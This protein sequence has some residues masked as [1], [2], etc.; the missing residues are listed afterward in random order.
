MA[1][2]TPVPS[3]IWPPA[4]ALHQPFWSFGVIRLRWT[5]TF[6]FLLLLLP[7]GLLLRDPRPRAEGLERLLGQAALLQSFPAAPERPVPALWSQRLG[8]AEARRVWRQQR[9]F[10]WQFWGGDGDAGAFLAYQ[11]DSASPPPPNGIRVDDLVVVAANPL[12]KQLLQDQL[13]L[14]QPQRRGLEQRCLQRLQQEQA[15][16]WAPLGLGV[17]AG[18]AAPFLQRFQQGC[19]SLALDV[20]NLGIT[21][22]AAAASGLLSAPGPSAPAV[23]PPPLPAELLLEWRGPALEGLL[24]GLLSRQLIREPLAAR[25]GI[26]DAQMIMLGRV[27]F[28]LRLRPLAQGPFQ[29]GLELELAVSGDRSPWN[30]M[31]AGIVEPLESQGLVATPSGSKV[32][33]AMKWRQQNGQVVGGWRWTLAGSSSPELLLFLGPEPPAPFIPVLR[34]P[35]LG[36]SMQLRLRPAALAERGLLPPELPKP[37]QRANQLSLTAAP[38]LP[39]SAL[40]Q[41]TGQLQLQSR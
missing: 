8:A 30:Q 15:V 16:F 37:V 32:L 41:L 33:A 2:P 20:A 23:V 12:A 1:A 34:R 24:Q 11:F 6:T 21:G 5:F 4:T 17:L 31:L 7:T 14:A 22:E 40:S 13:K 3:P 39:G 38:S 28:T 36:G 25:Y 19:L 9:R 18:S 27:P 10:W 26:G 35:G 29:T